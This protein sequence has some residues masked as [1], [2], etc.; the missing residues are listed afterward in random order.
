VLRTSCNF[1]LRCVINSKQG[2]MHGLI[3]GLYSV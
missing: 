3:L 2:V 1:K